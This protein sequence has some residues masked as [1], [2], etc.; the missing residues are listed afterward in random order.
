MLSIALIAFWEGSETRK[1]GDAL[2]VSTCFYDYLLT[3]L[4]SLKSEQVDGKVPVL[5]QLA[6]ACKL[7]GI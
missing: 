3:C 5:M 4:N 2:L 7:I 6:N 1:D